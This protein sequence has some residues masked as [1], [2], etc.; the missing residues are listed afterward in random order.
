MATK[1][2]QVLSSTNVNSGIANVVMN[3]YRNIDREKVQF[4]FLIF[5]EAPKNYNEEIKSLG[6][7]VYY[8]TKPG[9]KT[10][11]KAKKELKAF[12]SQHKDEYDIIHCHEILVAKQVFKY[13][14]KYSRP[15]CISHS[16]NSRLADGFIKQ[17]RNRLLVTGLGKKSDY[18]F[19]CSKE[20]GQN[21]FGKFDLTKDKYKVIYNS[22][23]L[24]R[25]KFSEEGREIVRK[26][27]GIEDGL[28]LGNIGRLCFQKNQLFAIKVLQEIIK[29][30][31]DAKL[32]IVGE[33]QDK[34]KLQEYV[35]EN[36]LQENVIFTGIR[37]DVP[38]LLSA[39][40]CFVFPSVYEGLPVGLVEA[41]ASGVKCFC[42]ES[43]TSE[44]YLTGSLVVFKNDD[45]P[46]V[47]AN[48]II[49]S[50]DD[51]VDRNKGYEQVKAKGFDIKDSAKELEKIYF[52]IKSERV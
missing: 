41:Q 19:A 5:W 45:S 40:D 27:F 10:F 22:I 25:F 48:K 49:E 34:E 46:L 7:N 37:K 30:K 13:A 38:E 12:F 31:Q 17:V 16:H 23:N 33:G 11:F 51:N 4:D 24:P 39:M 20:A 52:E 47:W 32:L 29:T 21:A 15:V 43:I 2:L 36:S 14:R 28:L 50:L 18:C 8:F 35:R 9:L 1:V 42:F 3:Y 26:E 44:V 6:G